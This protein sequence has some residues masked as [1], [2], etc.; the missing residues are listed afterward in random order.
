[1]EPPA[2]API[3]SA[4]RRSPRPRRAASALA[5]LALAGT[6]VVAGAS[7][8]AV[9]AS[10]TMLPGIDVSHH[11]GTIDWSQVK[12]AGMKFA[13]AKASEGTTFVD[14][15]FAA[16]R[17]GAAAQ[18]I[19]FGGYHFA[20]PSG[21]TSSAIAADAKAEADHFV[22]T[23]SP[24]TSNLLPVLDLETS[25]G[26]SIASLQAWTW[27]FLDE[28]VARIRE[29]PI[30]YSGNYFWATYMGDTTQYADAGFK[31]LW[32]PHWT[33]APQ[34]RVPA[35]DWGGHGWTFWQYASCGH[36]PGVSGCADMDKFNGTDLTGSEYGIPPRNTSP[37]TITGQPEETST[38]TAA[39]GSWSGTG[40]LAYT[41]RWRRC[42]SGGGSCAYIP[43]ATSSTYTLG[44]ADVDTLVSVEVS[45]SNGMGS[46]TAAS[47][48]TQPVQPY[49]VTP[50]SVPVFT[51]PSSPYW[52]S[53]ALPVAWS[54]TDDRS[55]VGSYHVRVRVAAAIGSFGGYHDVFASTPDTQ[56]TFT[57]SPGKTY[58][59]IAMA[60]DRWQ[61]TSAWSGEQCATVPI[62]DHAFT[63]STG[64]TVQ[65]DA[66]FF[67][68]TALAT[69]TRGA[70]LLHTGLVAHRIRVLAE[71]CPTCGRVQVM[72]RGRVV[73]A[74]DL[75][76]R[77]TQRRHLMPEIDLPAVST[78]SLRIRATT[79]NR[80]VV[81]D[82][83][84]VTQR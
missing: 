24:R 62:D 66:G 30:I 3:P 75:V 58:C 76:T 59:F 84:A 19:P 40:P 14:P 2:R 23:V 38:L 57:A 1:M 44:A 54:S 80:P 53:T 82:G 55:G 71:T 72:W 4:L 68:G 28:V 37:P 20:R 51:A 49:D 15:Q 11:N 27:G 48:P 6:L 26:L 18:H 50:P 61:N 36:V 56:T 41:Y 77:T 67:R 65:R 35:K 9:A 32:V 13:F 10:G 63:A 47:G 70:S 5:A 81:I 8:A 33:N 52:S 29:R 79:A 64:W 74:F 42:D 69:S 39:P 46:A 17:A 22:D 78:G 12:A 25:G 31:L 7:P 34:P 21:S 83:V 45:A 60:T 43:G 16:N 73:G